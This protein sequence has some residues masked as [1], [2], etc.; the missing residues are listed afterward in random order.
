MPL[1]AAY[2]WHLRREQPPRD[3]GPDQYHV[4]LFGPTGVGLVTAHPVGLVAMLGVF[5]MA[6]VGLPEARWFFG[7]ALLLGGIFALG[8]RLRERHT[9]LSVLEHFRQRLR[10]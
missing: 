4:A 1:H 9:N 6:L 5:F 8:L 7:A 3:S 2:S 10:N